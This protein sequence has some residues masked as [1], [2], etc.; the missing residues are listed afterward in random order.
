MRDAIDL[1]KAYV[2]TVLFVVGPGVAVAVTLI[3]AIT[4][5]SCEDHNDSD[6]RQSSQQEKIL[7][8]AAAQ[9]GMPAIKNFRERKL[10]KDIYEL[11]DQDGLTTYTYLV[12]EHDAKLVFL[13]DSIGYS[14]PYATQFTSPQKP[15][16]SQDGNFT[17]PQADPNGL[18]T[19]AT[20]EGTWVLCKDPNGKDVKVVYVEPRIVVSPFRLGVEQPKAEQPSK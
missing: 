5:T 4:L 10:L 1:I 14:V 20:A 11:R 6:T 19:P 2:L 13:C 9:V 15:I 17:L 18:F 12:S 3:G 16:W 8:E 7:G